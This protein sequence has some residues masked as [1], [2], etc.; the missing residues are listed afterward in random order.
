MSVRQTVNSAETPAPDRFFEL[1]FRLHVS[2]LTKALC[3]F[4]CSSFSCA[5]SDICGY[6]KSYIWDKLLAIFTPD[7]SRQC[8]DRVV[9][10]IVNRARGNFMATAARRIYISD[11][12]PIFPGLRRQKATVLAL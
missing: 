1:S 5:P 4:P 2:S 10:G 6:C 11:F 9:V 3:G 8:W 7:I 12:L